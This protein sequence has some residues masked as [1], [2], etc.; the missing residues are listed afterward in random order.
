M[1]WRKPTARD[2]N[3]AGGSADETRRTIPDYDATAGARMRTI[4]GYSGQQPGDPAR[5]AAAI[6]QT[7]ESDHPLRLLLDKIGLET[8]AAKLAAI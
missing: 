1:P 6:V 2:P 8:A 3:G 7:V 4:R 5:A